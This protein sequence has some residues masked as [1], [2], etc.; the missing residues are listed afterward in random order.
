MSDQEA[1]HELCDLYLQEQDYAKAAF[2]MEELILHNPHSHLIYQRYAEIKYSQV[3]AV[4]ILL[5]RT[6]V[7]IFFGTSTIQIFREVS[8]TWNRQRCTLHRQ[9]NWIHRIHAPFLDCYW[10]VTWNYFQE[11]RLTE[12]IWAENCHCSIAIQLCYFAAKIDSVN[13]RF[14]VCVAACC[15]WD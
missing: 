7:E 10:W 12:D 4:Y 1:W 11:V 14:C 8:R 2:C 9:S 15:V 3:R 5:C 13:E 6:P